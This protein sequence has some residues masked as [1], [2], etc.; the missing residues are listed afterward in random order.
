MKRIVS[1]ILAVG[2]LFNIYTFESLAKEEDNTVEVQCAYIHDVG[3]NS[4]KLQTNVVDEGVY[5]Q[6]IQDF[7]LNFANDG[8][9]NVSGGIDNQYFDFQLVAYDSPV[10]KNVQ[11]FSGTDQE[12]KFELLYASIEKEIE[13]SAIYFVDMKTNDKKYSN[14]FKLYLRP[15]GSED[16]I[17]VEIFFKKNVGKQYFKEFDPNTVSDEIK[18]EQFWYAK[19]FTPETSMTS[20][21]GIR[22]ISSD[23]NTITYVSRFDHLGLQF[24]QHFQIQR[25]ISYPNSFRNEGTFTTSLG[26][27]DEYT[28]CTT[29]PNENSDDSYIQINAARMDIAVDEG[30]AVS[31]YEIDGSVHYPARADVTFG[32]NTG[33]SLWGAASID[34]SYS[35]DDDNHDLNESVQ[36]LTNGSNGYHR[37]LGVELDSRAL[38]DQV[39]HNFT[40]E[41]TVA[42]YSGSKTHQGFK[43]QF[44]Y[45]MLNTMEYTDWITDNWTFSE[46]K[47]YDT[48]D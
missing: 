9:V 33:V 21:L 45:H 1:L 18:K 46:T 41:W 20:D 35:Q 3:T 24:N 27:T 30:D 31:K 12:K 37:Q 23:S 4:S 14:V 5:K 39:G 34:L 29:N 43:V 8:L 36:I 7:S 25:Y 38:L 42:N 15:S 6:E 16:F 22:T 10:N 11:I 40:T 48:L 44:S 19:V 2:V 28:E 13:N 26:V 32:W 47:Y 17:A